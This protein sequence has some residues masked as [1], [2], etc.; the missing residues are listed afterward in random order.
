MRQIQ[1]RKIRNNQLRE[2]IARIKK[3][4][5]ES[6]ESKMIDYLLKFG[7]SNRKI[8]QL[9]LNPIEQIKAMRPKELFPDFK[10]SYTL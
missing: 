10:P 6:K 1:K 9:L 3:K 7:V 5:A 4:M 8:E 2:K